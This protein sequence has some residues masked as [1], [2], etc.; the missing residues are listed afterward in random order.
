MLRSCAGMLILFVGARTLSPSASSGVLKQS[1]VPVLNAPDEGL[2]ARPI[3]C[4]QRIDDEP[5]ARAIQQ[6]ARSADPHRTHA[7]ILR[8]SAMTP[9]TFDEWEVLGCQL[10]A[11]GNINVKQYIDFVDETL[12]RLVPFVSLPRVELL[13]P[14]NGAIYDH[15]PR[16]TAVSWKAAAGAVRYLVEVQQEEL[17]PGRAGDGSIRL[18]HVGWVPHNDGL[19]SAAVTGTDAVFY[20]IGAQQ[21]RVRVRALAENGHSGA[22]SSWREFRFTR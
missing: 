11:Q 1:D 5:A 16:R 15:Y 20:F 9:H 6:L 21:G 17:R 10:L 3:Q 19:H 8:Q 4:R 18:E 22:P 14:K 2:V 13:E 7:E 12:P